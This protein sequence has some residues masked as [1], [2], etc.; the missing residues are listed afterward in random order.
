MFC[1]TAGRQSVG[2]WLTVVLENFPRGRERTAGIPSGS[3]G[4]RKLVVQ[5]PRRADE[6]NVG[7]GLGKVP[8]MLAAWAKLLGVKADVVGVTERL[9]KNEAGFLQIIAPGQAFDIPK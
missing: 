7:K 1:Q 6:R 8:Q 5:N 2:V 4:M 3:F 9:F